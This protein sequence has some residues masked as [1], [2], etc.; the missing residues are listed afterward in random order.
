MT[1]LVSHNYH[2]IFDGHYGTAR[3]TYLYVVRQ[4]FGCPGGAG[5]IQQKAM[6]LRLST[7][8]YLIVL[9]FGTMLLSLR[10]HLR[11]L[12]AW[13]RQHGAAVCKSAAFQM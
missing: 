12:D 10:H 13:A 6:L 8:E 1:S 4:Q 11:G 7:T 3:V 9:E 2:C 5:L